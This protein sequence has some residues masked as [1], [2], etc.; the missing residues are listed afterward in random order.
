MTTRMGQTYERP[1]MADRDWL[2]TA[3]TAAIMRRELKAAFPRVKF[4]VKSSVYSMGS[5]VHIGW[6]DGPTEERVSAITDKYS[7]RGFDG[8]ID[9]EY[10]IKHYMMPDGSIGVAGSGGTEGSMGY[11]P[12]FANP[13]PINARI[14]HLGSG[15]VFCQ[16]QHSDALKDACGPQVPTNIALHEREGWLWRICRETEGS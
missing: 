13:I 11:V 16:R 9:L 2:T 14:V 10:Q 8:S 7:S 15:Y 1:A 6:T 5:S 3:E 4:S 12:R